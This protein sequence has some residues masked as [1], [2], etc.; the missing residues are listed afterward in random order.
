[1][2]GAAAGA[3]GVGDRVRRLVVDA[4]GYVARGRRGTRAEVEQT[5]R[6]LSCVQL[7]S[8]S[9]VERSHRIALSSRVGDYP[10]GS[11]PALLRGGRLFEYWAHEACLLPVEWWPVCRPAMEAGGRHWYGD[12]L[13]KHPDVV[14]HVLE[15]I[16][17]RGPLGSRDF[18]GASW[19][20]MWSWKPAKGALEASL[21]T[22]A[23][24]SS[25]TAHVPALLRPDRAGDPSGDPG[26]PGSVPA[27]VR[28][29]RW[30]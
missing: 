25:P 24:S 21:G 14:G 18:E 27:R 7:D 28:R 10:R 22:T 5:V 17:A 8:I 15:E 16:R 6:R 20:G 11:V 23:T 13:R 3:S 29:G 4:Q 1:M 2:H 19:G 12:V 30:R 26:R 9:V